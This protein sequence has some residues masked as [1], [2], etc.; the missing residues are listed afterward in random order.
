[1]TAPPP[2]PYFMIF[3]GS[4]LFDEAPSCVGMGTPNPQASF[5][6]Y[7][8]LVSQCESGEATWVLPHCATAELRGDGW[9]CPL[10]PQPQPNLHPPPPPSVLH[11]LNM[12]HCMP[13]QPA[14]M[15]STPPPRLHLFVQWWKAPFLVPPTPLVHFTAIR[16]P[17]PPQVKLG[18]VLIPVWSTL[19]PSVVML[20]HFLTLKS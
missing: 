6:V 1:M 13:N 19:L 10:H 15:E 16:T 20:S 7:S 2:P 4:H 11:P 14:F 12:L 18:H 9:I 5:L 8:E 17:P 3:R